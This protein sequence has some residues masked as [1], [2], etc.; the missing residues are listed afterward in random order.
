M[1][2]DLDL[3][4]TLSV[5]E[6]NNLKEKLETALESIHKDLTVVE[7]KLKVAMGDENTTHSELQPLLSYRN[8]LKQVHDQVKYDNDQVNRF[9]NQGQRSAVFTNPGSVRFATGTVSIRGNDSQSRP[10]PGAKT[11]Q[12]ILEERSKNEEAKILADLDAK[13]KKLEEFRKVEQS[14]KQTQLQSQTQSQSSQT[15]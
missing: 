6:Q 7:K 14:K 15:A 10:V 3:F 1:P 9:I 11:F 13:M 8:E 5:K 4:R 2:I 12:Q